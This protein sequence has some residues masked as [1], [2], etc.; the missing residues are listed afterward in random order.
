MHALV[1]VKRWLNNRLTVI[2]VW[3]GVDSLTVLVEL[4]FAWAWPDTAW[5]DLAVV[6]LVLWATL[7]WPEWKLG[8]RLNEVALSFGAVV[9]GEC[10]TELWTAGTAWDS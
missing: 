8:N 6:A 10:W 2:Q 3:V 1:N 4:L 7:A 9:N 5:A